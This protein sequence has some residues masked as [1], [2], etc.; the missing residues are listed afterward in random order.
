V[1]SLLPVAAAQEKRPIDIKVIANELEQ[2]I[3]ACPKRIQINEESGKHH[4][5]RWTKTEW[6]PPKD[7]LADAV[8]YDSAIYSFIVTVEFSITYS[9]GPEHQSKSDAENDDSL[10][11][12]LFAMPSDRK[13]HYRN[14]YL[15]GNEGIRLKAREI[16]ENP[17]DAGSAVVWKERPIWPDACWDHVG[18]GRGDGG[19]Q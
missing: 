10:S 18:E 3:G 7:V 16:R 15:V 13:A 11:P 8:P 19:S 14:I 2:Q 12:L 6:G 5:Q 17:S 9:F 1:I 4:K